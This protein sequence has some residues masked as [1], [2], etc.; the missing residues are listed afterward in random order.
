MIREFSYHVSTVDSILCM[1]GYQVIVL[2]CGCVTI[3][4][5]WKLGSLHIFVAVFFKRITSILFFHEP[6]LSWFLNKGSVRTCELYSR[7][8]LNLHWVRK[9]LGWLWKGLNISIAIL[10]SARV[11]LRFLGMT[12]FRF[13]KNKSVLR[14]T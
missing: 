9:S 12:I 7:P 2:T 5:W 10:W 11:S 14:I 4:G 6:S 13:S 1:R 3:L 8:L